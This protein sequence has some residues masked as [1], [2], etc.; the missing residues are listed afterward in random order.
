MFQ[1]PDITS[2]YRRTDNSIG[3]TL[4]NIVLELKPEKIVEF[5]VMHGY[6]AIC[7]GQAL[8]DLGKGHLYAYDIWSPVYKKEDAE[9]N[10]RNFGLNQWITLGDG[11]W[12][13]FKD[14]FGLLHIDV[15]NNGDIIKAL[16]MRFPD[17][18]VIFEGGTKERD[19]AKPNATP[20]EGS[21]PYKVLNLKFPGISKLT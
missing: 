4:Y 20:M 6:S 12:N 15:N 1:V 11:D 19:E 2:S 21:A 5:G 10:I 17:K 14:D 16:S 18:H 8:R 9:R 7:M 3:V 13:E